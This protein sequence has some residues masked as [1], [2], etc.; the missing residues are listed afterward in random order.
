[1]KKVLFFIGCLALV[2]SI[3]LADTCTTYG[4]YSASQQQFICGGN[5][6][7]TCTYRCESSDNR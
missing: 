1:M 4:Y 6:N 5:G 7:T 2:P 3:A